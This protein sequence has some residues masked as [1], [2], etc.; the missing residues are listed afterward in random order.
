MG[1][2]KIKTKPLNTVILKPIPKVL[3]DKFLNIHSR[4][5]GWKCTGKPFSGCE[6]CWNCAFF[7]IGSQSCVWRYIDLPDEQSQFIEDPDWYRCG[8]WK[9]S[10]YVV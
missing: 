8:Y 7:R 1:R 4:R 2:V 6:V 9:E 3:Y 5:A 10:K